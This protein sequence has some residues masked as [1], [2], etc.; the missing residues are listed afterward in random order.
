M[1]IS[2]SPRLGLIIAVILWASA[3]FGADPPKVKRL[4]EGGTPAHKVMIGEAEYIGV[5]LTGAVFKARIDTGAT[6]SSIFAA[7]VEEFER[8]GDPWVRFV[9]RNDD[10]DETFP[11]EAAVAGVAKIKKRGQEGFTERPAVAMDL[12]MGDVTKRIDVNLADR[13]GFEFPLLIGRDFLAGFAIVDV[14][15]SYTQDTPGAP[16]REKKTSP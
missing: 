15:L 4:I 11:L 8:D 3:A 6:T 7:D 2:A 12:V 9:I 1:L 16:S 14:T 10:T 5:P 13:T